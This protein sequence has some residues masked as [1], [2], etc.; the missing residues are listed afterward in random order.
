MLGIEL[1]G[2]AVIFGAF[3]IVFL[4]A[5]VYSLYTKTGSGISQRPYKH[6]YGGAPGA[7]RVS[8]MSGSADRDIASWSRG[9]R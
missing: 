5:T 2:G 1:A 6:V 7:A 3:I 4:M 8:R 9:T